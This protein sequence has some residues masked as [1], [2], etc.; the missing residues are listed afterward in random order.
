LPDDLVAFATSIDANGRYNLTTRFAGGIGGYFTG[1]EWLIDA[2][3]NGIVTVT[4]IG[5]K[6]TKALLTLHYDKGQK[7]YELQQTIA[8]GDQ[9]WVNLAQLGRDRLADR[10]GN[11]LPADLGSVAYD[12]RDLSLGRAGLM[13]NSLA[14]DTT[15][16][17]RAVPPNA[18]TAACGVVHLLEVTVITRALHC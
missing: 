12:L 16:G 11:A 14:T 17:F 7:S 2:N 15:Y 5:S 9:M 10:N 13:V 1:G 18:T 3:H 8:P 4:N 6:S